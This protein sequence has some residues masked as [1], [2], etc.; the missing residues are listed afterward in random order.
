MTL[1]RSE[2][3]LTVDFNGKAAKYIQEPK[4]IIV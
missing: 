3:H 1:L 2:F 4:D